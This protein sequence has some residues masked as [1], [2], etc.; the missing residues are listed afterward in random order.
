MRTLW[1]LERLWPR[2]RVAEV[3]GQELVQ[4]LAAGKELQLVDVRDGAAFRAG[5]LPGAHNIPVQ[6]LEQSLTAL[7]PGQPTVVY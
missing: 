6:S 4:M 1:S 5:H 7:D 3:S 2:Q